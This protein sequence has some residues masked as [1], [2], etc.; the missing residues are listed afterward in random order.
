MLRKLRAFVFALLLVAA[1]G[2][3]AVPASAAPL[4]PS[5][6]PESTWQVY[7]PAL[8]WLTVY[9]TKY[10][11]SESAEKWEGKVWQYDGHATDP[12]A[13]TSEYRQYQSDMREADALENAGNIEGAAAIRARWNE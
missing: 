2:I 12:A 4:N 9:Y 10:F 13:P 1:V 6:K 7:V 5:D 3:T 11:V 8:N